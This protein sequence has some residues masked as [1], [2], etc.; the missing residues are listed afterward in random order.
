MDVTAGRPKHCVSDVIAACVDAENS[1]Q[2][3]R[4]LGVTGCRLTTTVCIDV[5]QHIS[6]NGQSMD[7]VTGRAAAMI[8]ANNTPLAISQL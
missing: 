2:T 4:Q 3:R 5:W 7:V 8:S 6:R 1:C